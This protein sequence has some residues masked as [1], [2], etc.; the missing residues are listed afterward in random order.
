M[1]S[2]ASFEN[3]PT[4]LSGLN[5]YATIGLSDVSLYALLAIPENSSDASGIP[6]ICGKIA[7]TADGWTVTI[8]LLPAEL[9][10]VTSTGLAELGFDTTIA[11]GECCAS[12]T[13]T[14][15]VEQV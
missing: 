2:D 11:N 6:I 5:W 13:H 7:C 14:G 1:S 8:W 4:L 12:S 15:W 9:V 3:T 10:S